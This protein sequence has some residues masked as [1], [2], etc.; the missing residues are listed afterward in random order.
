VPELSIV[1]FNT[2]AGVG[3]RRDDTRP[4]D[5]A[6][7]LRGFD[8]DVM[9]LQESFTPD[10]EP[11]AVQKVAA[12]LGAEVFEIPFGRA[13]SEP[14]PHIIRRRGVGTIGL[15]VFTRFP[16]RRVGELSLG[17]VPFDPV[18]GGRSALHLALDVDGTTVDLIGLHLTSR[19]PHG[20]VMQ[21]RR[22][23]DQ[24]PKDGPAIVAGDFNFWGPGVSV[25]LPGWQRPIRGRTWPAHRPHSQIDHVLTRPPIEAIEAHVLD[26]VGSDHRAVRAVLRLP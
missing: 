6:A 5:L 26:P 24:L 21:M 12:E 19:L 1:S 8:A 18:R 16:A 4:Y 2:H 7:V 23:R 15:A 17:K 25:F 3:P 14:W 11:A 22:L 20:P 9:V 10:D 13:V